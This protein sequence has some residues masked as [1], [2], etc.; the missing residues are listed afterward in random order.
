[1]SRNR[2]IELTIKY[3]NHWTEEEW[4]PTIDKYSIEFTPPNICP[5]LNERVLWFKWYN[6]EVIKT[7][8]S[9]KQPAEIIAN[10]RMWYDDGEKE[11]RIT[12][13]NYLVEDEEGNKLY[14]Y[15]LFYMDRT[16][17]YDPVEIEPFN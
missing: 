10:L 2:N 12:E 14:D 9:L 11:I 6:E 16:G 4:K 8:L 17:K 7:M 15:N 3:Q 5:E 13:K 1:M